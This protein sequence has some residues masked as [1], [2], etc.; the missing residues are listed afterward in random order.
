MLIK[1]LNAVIHRFK[2]MPIVMIHY[3]TK[4]YFVDLIKESLKLVVWCSK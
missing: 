1:Y 2:W 3:S 4:G